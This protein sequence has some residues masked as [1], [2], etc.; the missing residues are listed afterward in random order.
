M[1]ISRLRKLAWTVSLFAIGLTSISCNGTGG[2]IRPPVTTPT[3][4]GYFF[5]ADAPPVGTSVLKFEITL[6]NATL[7]PTVGATGECQGSSQVSLIDGPL[8]L[9]LNSL[10]LGS[11]F[12]S[13]KSVPVGAYAGVKLTFADYSLK[14][15]LP[16]GTI[17]VFDNTTLPL[18]ATSVT[19]TFTS[20]LTVANN[21][22]FGFLLDF[23]ANNS[24]QSTPTAV[25]GVSPAVSLVPLPIT[26]G[27]PIID[28]AARNG[29]VSSL[30]KTCTTNT[31]TFTFTDSLTGAEIANISFDSTTLIGE[32]T[33]ALAD[34]DITCDTF[35]NNQIVDVDILA[36]TNAQN[37]VEYFAQQIQL[38]GAATAARLEGTVFQ[39][40]TASEFVLFVES[41]E[42]LAV[43]P[44]GSFITVSFDPL[45]AVFR[46]DAGDLP[47]VTTDFDTG[48]DLL[49]GQTIKLDLTAGS[50]FMATTGCK[51][52]ADLCTA[53]ADSLRL[54]QTTLSGRVAGTADPKFTIDTLPSILGTASLLRPLSADCQLC[55]LGSVDVVTSSVTAFGSGL[56]NVSSLSVNNIVEVR[57]LL[58]KNGFTGPGP[59]S[60][61]RPTLVATQVRLQP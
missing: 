38:V 11:A 34:K 57:G 5:I 47:V 16:D 55:T 21:V 6:T 3:G 24:I 23:D 13:S 49:A 28:L 31:G 42:N 8:D 40:N 48:S 39:V 60:G 26:A 29:R 2:S 41:Q 17:K 25:T 37:A 36:R 19:P 45:T 4:T 44:T 46:M 12:L 14:V 1:Q 51:T 15:M 35:V 7:C 50:L 61:F 52:V 53:G 59:T 20:A 56:V 22:S 30:T 43:V 33:D 9:D 54:K 27:Q 10:Q 58:T 18:T 32:P